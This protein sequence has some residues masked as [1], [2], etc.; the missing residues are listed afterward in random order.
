MNGGKLTYN[1]ALM[2]RAE[3]GLYRQTGDKKHLDAAERTGKAADWF[4]S[5]PSPGK[6]GPDGKKAG[7]SDPA[8]PS[9]ADA[10][11]SVIV[12]RR[13]GRT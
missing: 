4:Q 2:I 10:Q 5:K 6:A 9:P 3:L 12:T 7:K 1:T 13:S 11:I 8:I